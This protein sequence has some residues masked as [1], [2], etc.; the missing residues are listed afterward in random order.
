MTDISYKGAHYIVLQTKQT[1]VAIDPL[2]PGQKTSKV[3]DKAQVQVATQPQFMRDLV[4]EQLVF[5][6]PGEYEAGEVS[7]SGFDVTSQLDPA[8]KSVMY[9]VTTADCVVGIVGHANPDQLGEVQL[10]QLGVIDILIIPVGGNGYTIDPHAAAKLTQRISPKIVIPVHYEEDGVPYE[11]PQLS[12][13]LFIKELGLTP[14]KEQTLKIKQPSQL[15]DT[16]TLVQLE[17]TA[18]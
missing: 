18:A 17:K 16:L 4:E 12:V 7:I 9:R 6:M 11:M 13:E 14:Q 10:E 5:S 2:V 8:V 15:P 1:T 3:F